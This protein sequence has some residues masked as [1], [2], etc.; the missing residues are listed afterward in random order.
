MLLQAGVVGVSWADPIP[1]TADGVP[2]LPI[3]TYEEIGLAPFSIPTGGTAPIGIVTT[4][5]AS[6]PPGDAGAGTGNGADSVSWAS[7][8]SQSWSA[9]SSQYAESLGVNPVAVAATCQ[10]EAGGCQTNPSSGSTT[11]TGTFQMRDD[12]YTSMINSALARNPNLASNIV[13]GLT[14]KLDP[15]TESIAAAEYLRQGAV[16]LQNNQIA[17]PTVLDVRGY[18]NF[19]PAPASVVALASGSSVLSDIVP[20]TAAQYKANGIIPG[21]TTVGQWRSSVTNQIGASAAQSPVLL[22]QS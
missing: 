20:L 11:I 8:S 17:N 5:P 14:G 6:T 4:P 2:P 1:Q 21:V 19:G 16:A 13:P 7:Y 15:A 22:N 9:A 12:T 10:I 18:Y 3:P